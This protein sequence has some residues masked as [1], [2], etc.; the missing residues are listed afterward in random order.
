MHMLNS[1]VVF[2]YWKIVVFTGD[3]WEE[4]NF[5]QTNFFIFLNPKTLQQA[6]LCILILLKIPVYN[7]A[8]IKFSQ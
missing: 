2:H 8:I 5:L 3:I 6:F 7:E 4:D 1:F